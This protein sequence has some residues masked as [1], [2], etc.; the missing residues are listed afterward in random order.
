MQDTA[1]ALP[2]RRAVLSW[3]FYDWANSPFTAV[4]TTFVIAAYYNN[5][6]ASTPEDGAAGWGFMMGVASLLVAVFSPVLGAIADHGGRRKPWLAVMTLSM[7]LGS[8]AIW[9]ATPGEASGLFILAVVAFAVVTFEMGMVFYN[10]MLPGLVAE[11]WLGRVSGW[12]WALGYIG[13]LAC[14]VLLL[15]VFIQA[16]VPP[17]GLD[18][19]QAEHVRIAGPIVAVWTILFSLPLFLFTPDRPG[20]GLGA[21]RAVRAGLAQL[22]GTIRNVR[23]Y[24]QIVRFLI[25]RMI[26]M[27]GV[28]TLFAFGGVYA[29]GTF[30]MKLE[31]VL[32]FGIVLNVTAGLG[33]FVFGWADDKLGAKPT[34][35]FSLL[36][37]A[38]IGTPLLIIESKL[39][40]MILGAGIGLFF[41]PVQAA[42]RSM[43]A[44]MAPKGMETEM[45][46]L[47]AFSGKSTSFL[48]PW[49]VGLIAGFAGQRVGLA[50]VVP[51]ILIGAALL[52]RVDPKR[53]EAVAVD[54][55][56]PGATG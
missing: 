35:L 55:D 32:I 8:A 54:L 6:I 14:L 34:I 36:A 44:R 26:F 42:A 38:A 16:E 28:N 3:C 25:A 52:W 10:A 15:V 51:L 29:A 27:D 22:A 37:I 24:R 13:G 4:V 5:A 9:F 12:A 2:K 39:W 20:T 7:S 41:G 23:Q 17:F 56:E 40:F 47:Y 46:G 49:L 18:K 1:P 30:G 48:G 11:T 43:M 31:E 33:A 45:F 53:P 21:A 50:I 19:A